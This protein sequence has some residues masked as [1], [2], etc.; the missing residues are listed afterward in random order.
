MVE[1]RALLEDSKPNMGIFNQQ[2]DKWTPNKLNLPETK[3][4]KYS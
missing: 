1:S 3:Q 2:K 4:K